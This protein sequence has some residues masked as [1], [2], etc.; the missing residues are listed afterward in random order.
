[1]KPL[2]NALCRWWRCVKQLK[3]PRILNLYMRSNLRLV[4]NCLISYKTREVFRVLIAKYLTVLAYIM[5]H[6]SFLQLILHVL[7][8]YIRYL[9][10]FRDITDILRFWRGKIEFCFIYWKDNESNCFAVLLG[11]LINHWL[12]LFERRIRVNVVVEL[13]CWISVLM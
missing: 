8:G 12:H 3:M 9:L 10:I 6:V 7:H 1:L 11:A 2:Y 5:V 4:Q 13:A